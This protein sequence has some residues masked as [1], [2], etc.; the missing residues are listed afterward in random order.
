MGITSE[1]VAE[2]F[3]VSRTDQARAPAA[4]DSTPTMPP[5]ASSPTHSSHAPART[6]PPPGQARRG[7]PPPRCQLPRL[8]PLQ[9]RD[10][11]RGDKSEERAGRDGGPPGHR[12]RRHPRRRELRRAGKAQPG[13]QEG[14]DDD[15][16]QLLPGDGRRRVR[17]P[18]APLLRQGEGPPGHRR[19]A[20]LLRRRCRPG[21]HGADETHPISLTTLSRL[22]F[23]F[24]SFSFRSRAPPRLAHIFIAAHLRRASARPT[25]FRRPSA[26]R[27]WARAT[28][29][30]TS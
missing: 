4:A 7:V 15:G 23:W 2:K 3:G 26:W 17:A 24:S 8:W 21:P 30:S 19:V 1:N 27:A 10:R 25:R 20:R 14:R 28:W 6:P 16:G 5:T 9:A 29:P 12:G 13:I 11:P 22:S 18:R